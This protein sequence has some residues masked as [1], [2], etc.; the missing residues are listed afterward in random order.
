MKTLLYLT[1]TLEE[2]PSFFQ[3]GDLA[4]GLGF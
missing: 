4:P 3:K 2:T 1:V